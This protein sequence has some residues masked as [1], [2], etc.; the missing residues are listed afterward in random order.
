MHQGSK[1]CFA[2]KIKMLRE[3]RDKGEL[4][5]LAQTGERREF[6]EHFVNPWG[7]GD[8]SLGVQGQ[9]GEAPGLLMKL[10]PK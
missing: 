8:E 9:G 5:L 1:C 10:Q 4:I 3:T 2:D 6:K 7:S